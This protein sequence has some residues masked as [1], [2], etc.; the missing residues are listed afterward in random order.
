MSS[1][2]VAWRLASSRRKSAICG[3]TESSGRFIR[4]FAMV[5][6]VMK[7][8]HLAWYVC[9]RCAG[10]EAILSDEVEES[11]FPDSRGNEFQN[12]HPMPQG[13]RRWRYE[14]TTA[15][16]GAPVIAPRLGVA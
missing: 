8:P 1:R 15:G 4:S 6:L 16:A 9:A 5:V 13:R 10:G 11:Q 14:G 3:S 7:W 2:P 12:G